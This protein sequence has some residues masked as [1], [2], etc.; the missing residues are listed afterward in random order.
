MIHNYNHF[1]SGI[2]KNKDIDSNNSDYKK[3]VIVLQQVEVMIEKELTYYQINSEGSLNYEMLHY[4][5]IFKSNTVN[6][7]INRIGFEKID[8]VVN[9]SINKYQSYLKDITGIIKFPNNLFVE[10]ILQNNFEYLSKSLID[11]LMFVFKFFVFNKIY[12]L[13]FKEHV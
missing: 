1:V 3:G 11:D 6:E 5:N 4:I 9:E 13:K 7:F 10:N 2:L 12:E 8:I